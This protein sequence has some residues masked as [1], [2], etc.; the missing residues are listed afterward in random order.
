MTAHKLDDNRTDSGLFKVSQSKAKQYRECRRKW[1][2]AHVM[3]LARKKPVRPLTFGSIVHKMKETWAEGGDPISVLDGL[4]RQDLEAYADDVEQF[5]DIVEDIRYI[6]EAYMAFWADRE[7]KYLPH[8]RCYAEHSFEVEIPKEKILVKGTIDAVTQHRKYNWLTEHKNH[9]SI[10]N[11]DERWRSVQSVVYIKVIAILGWWK[12]IEGTCWDY[13]R[14][15]SPSRPELLKDGSVSRRKIDTLPQVVRDT[16]RAYKKDPNY[17]SLVDAAELNMPTYFQR[18]YTPIKRQLV[19]KVWEGFLS[20][21]REMRDAKL[22]EP[23]MTIGR[24]CSWCPFESICRA[25]LTGGDVDFVIEHEYVPS[26]Y[27]E[28]NEEGTD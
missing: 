11:D 27:G 9:K 14:T 15:K 26:T 7:L 21:A 6:F 4:P 12:D 23:V 19:D 20:T 17:K 25:E 22:R 16:L 3:R 28:S 2:Y 5:G 10:P 1:W 18:V 13:I 8:D 24:H